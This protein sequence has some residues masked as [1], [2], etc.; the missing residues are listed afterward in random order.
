MPLTEFIGGSLRKPLTMLLIA[1]GMV[2]LIACANI[3]GLQIARA[4]ARQRELAVRV[5]L[6][7]Q[8][9]RLLRQAVVESIVL[10]VAGLALGFAVAMATAPLLLRSRPPSWAPRFSL[11]TAGRCC[12]L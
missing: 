5:A 12:Y 9:V 6:G 8:R 3:A 2:L 1:V 11:P 4:S 10:T 7:A